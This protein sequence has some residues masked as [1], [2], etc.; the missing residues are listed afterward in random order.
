[1]YIYMLYMSH[2]DFDA[3]ETCWEVGQF[4]NSRFR[5][6]YRLLSLFLTSSQAKLHQATTTHTKPRQVTL[7]LTVQKIPKIPKSE[8]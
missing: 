2:K 6:Q 5:E 4:Q 1:M 8:V 3:G 7:I